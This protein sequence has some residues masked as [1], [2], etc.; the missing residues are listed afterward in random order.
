M[1][2]QNEQSSFW[3]QETYNLMVGGNI[4]LWGINISKEKHVMIIY[5]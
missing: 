1:G 2:Y 4:Y 3:P 5:R